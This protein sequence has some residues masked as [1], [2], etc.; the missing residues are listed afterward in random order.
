MNP[1]KNERVSAAIEFAKAALVD[2]ENP[3]DGMSPDGYGEAAERA[4]VLRQLLAI[5]E[6]EAWCPPHSYTARSTCVPGDALLA[7]EVCGDRFIG[8]WSDEQA[9][10]RPADRPDPCPTCGGI[11]LRFSDPSGTNCP[12]CQG[13]ATAPPDTKRIALVIAEHERVE[14]NRRRLVAQGHYGRDK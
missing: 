8:R 5:L 2:A 9:E 11:G 13:S 12:T 14:G 3:Y 10:S 1:I 6:P 4:T 7:C